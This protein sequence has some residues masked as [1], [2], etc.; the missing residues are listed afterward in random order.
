[1]TLDTRLIHSGSVGDDVGGTANWLHYSV[2][3]RSVHISLSSPYLSWP[4]FVWT[5]CA[6]I[7][8]SHGGV[9]SVWCEA[10]QFAVAATDHGALSSKVRRDEVRRGEV[11][12]DE[13]S[14]L[15]TPLTGASNRHAILYAVILKC[16]EKNVTKKNNE[17]TRKVDKTRKLDLES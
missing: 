10:T 11:T 17:K 15:N 13:R 8:R 16:T 14:D 1:M 6:V 7:G 5:E 4:Y 3:I 9:G 12:W 2:L